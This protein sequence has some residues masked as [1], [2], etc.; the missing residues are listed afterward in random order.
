[1]PPAPLDAISPLESFPRQR[2]GYTILLD[3]KA[4]L[5]AIILGK[6][7]Y[8]LEHLTVLLEYRLYV[9]STAY[10][11]FNIQ[12][13]EYTYYNILSTCY[14]CSSKHKYKSNSKT[15]LYLKQKFAQH[16]VKM[17]SLLHTLHNIPLLC[18]SRMS[19]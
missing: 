7:Y 15:D 11:V 18:K 9:Y 14:M 1:M 19:M 2:P 10:I 6:C 3:N 8:S 13:F 5:I 12:E 16:S 4:H 17:I